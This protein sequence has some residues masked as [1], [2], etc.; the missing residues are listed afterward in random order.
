VAIKWLK[1]KGWDVI[2]YMADVGQQ[3]DFESYRKRALK[4]I[5]VT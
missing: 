5:I 2:A 4:T 1:D 3:S